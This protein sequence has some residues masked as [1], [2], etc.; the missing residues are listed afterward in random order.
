[1]KHEGF[2]YTAHGDDALVELYDYE[3]AFED[4]MVGKLLD[5]LDTSG[6]AKTTTVVL[7]ADHGEGF[8]VHVIAGQRDFFHGD[9]LYN[10]L[11]H[12]PL[13]FRIPGAKPC[14]RDDVVQ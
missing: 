11:I 1:M 12:V 7:M 2:S 8:G 10:E 5:A 13:M 4:I 3:I 9:S 6:L 14:K